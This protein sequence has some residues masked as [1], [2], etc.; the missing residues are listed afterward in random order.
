MIIYVLIFCA[1]SLAFICK[2]DYGVYGGVLALM[3]IIMGFN[4]D[5]ADFRNY[6]FLFNYIN[7]WEDVFNETATFTEP[8][9]SLIFYI[10]KKVFGMNYY[11]CL[12]LISC[13]FLGI[14]TCMIIRYS[15]YPAFVLALYFLAPFFPCDIIQ[16]RNFMSEVIVCSV[17]IWFLNLKEYSRKDIFRYVIFI[18]MAS[19]FHVTALFYLLFLGVVFLKNERIYRLSV[20]IGIFTVSLFPQIIMNLPFIPTYKVNHYLS[21]AATKGNARDFILVYVMLV[22]FFLCGYMTKRLN[23]DSE[24]NFSVK[25][26]K[27]HWM[28]FLCMALI[29]FYNSAFYRLPRN[30]LLLDYFVLD[31]YNSR[32]LDNY[33]LMN[34]LYVLCALLWST[35]NVFSEW[36]VVLYNNQILGGLF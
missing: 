13:V 1:L 6:L 8:G 10:C 20:L 14:L 12:L 19:A 31:K 21:S 9:V 25:V 11:M 26:Y 7:G 36:N 18:L 22:Q 5:N 15:H 33:R 30:I 27:I 2:K 28:I 16:I 23:R 17:I 29:L 3:V 32:R 34:V 24:D 4:T 35:V